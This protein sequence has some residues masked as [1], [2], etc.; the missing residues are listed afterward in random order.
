MVNNGEL[1]PVRTHVFPSHDW[2]SSL[3]CWGGVLWWTPPV[4]GNLYSMKQAVIFGQLQLQ[5]WISLFC[6]ILFFSFPF[7]S[8]SD[9]LTT[10]AH[11]V[12]FK[13]KHLFISYH[14]VGNPHSLKPVL[15]VNKGTLWGV[16]RSGIQERAGKPHRSSLPPPVPLGTRQWDSQVGWTSLLLLRGSLAGEQI[17][18]VSKKMCKESAVYT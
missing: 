18:R 6:F 1:V 15:V 5:E 8:F 11:T 12:L 14:H 9:Y 16:W 7:L 17:K 10:S 2:L 13:F 4:M 3:P